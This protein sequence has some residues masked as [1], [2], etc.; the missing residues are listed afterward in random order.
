[1]MLLSFSKSPCR[2]Q[3]ALKR[4]THRERE[5]HADVLRQIFQ[6]TQLLSHQGSVNKTVNSCARLRIAEWASSLVQ[7]Q[8]GEHKET[9]TPKDKL[10]TQEFKEKTWKKGRFSLA[11][12]MLHHKHHKYHGTFQVDS[13]QTAYPHKLQRLP[14]TSLCWHRLYRVLFLSSPSVRLFFYLILII[15]PVSPSACLSVRQCAVFNMLR[16][17][18]STP[19]CHGTNLLLCLHSQLIWP[20]PCFGILFVTL[21]EVFRAA[22]RGE[23]HVPRSA[24]APIH[25][26]SSSISFKLPFSCSRQNTVLEKQRLSK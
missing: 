9:K 10:A 8:H 16:G 14:H 21:G 23:R 11:E 22:H 2:C 26:A 17:H 5:R 6:N 12:V 24:E 7:E 20:N 19:K 15:L 18:M 1:M 13:R 25:T 3:C 4:S